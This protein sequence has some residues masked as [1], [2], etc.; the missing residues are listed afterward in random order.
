MYY[1]IYKIQSSLWQPNTS[2]ALIS[3]NISIEHFLPVFNVYTYIGSVV[4]YGH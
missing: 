3:E 4:D 1:F 2:I